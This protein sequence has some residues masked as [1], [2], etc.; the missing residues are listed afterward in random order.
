MQAL[1]ADPRSTWTGRDSKFS[2]KEQRLD[3][4]TGR[5]FAILDGLADFDTNMDGK[6]TTAFLVQPLH[7]EDLGPDGDP[8]VVTWTQSPSRLKL[9]QKLEEAGDAIGPVAVKMI[10]NDL[11]G[12]K[13]F[14]H[15][16][17]YQG[18]TATPADDEDDQPL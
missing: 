16:T 1:P 13:P 14:R 5:P 4:D 11:P 10:P 2:T 18:A 7:P 15:V 9:I 3:L 8:Y 12:R 6:P 17:S